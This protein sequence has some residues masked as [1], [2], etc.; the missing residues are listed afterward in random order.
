MHLHRVSSWPAWSGAARTRSRAA[1]RRVARGSWCRELRGVR[2]LGV[3]A[4]KAL[5]RALGR[6]VLTARTQQLDAQ[7][8]PLLAEHTAR[9]AAL[10]LGER[11]FRVGERSAAQL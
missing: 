9:E 7:H 3:A 2:A 10:E 8:V 4:Q 6:R 11:A 5:D 1:R